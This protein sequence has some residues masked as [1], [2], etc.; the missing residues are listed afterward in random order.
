M[1]GLGNGPVRAYLPMAGCGG[2]CMTTIIVICVMIMV[3]ACFVAG[4]TNGG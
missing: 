3:L 4:A 2:G 1:I